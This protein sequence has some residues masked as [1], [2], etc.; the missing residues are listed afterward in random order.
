M[1]LRRPTA[2]PALGLGVSLV[3][4]LLLDGCTSPAGAASTSGTVVQYA[5][6]VSVADGDTVNVRLTRGGAYRRVRLLGIDTPEVYG[7]VVEC[8]GPEALA[9]MKRMLPPGTF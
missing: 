3:A 1:P 5:R 7:P 4:G 9:A 6:V 8:G 2:L